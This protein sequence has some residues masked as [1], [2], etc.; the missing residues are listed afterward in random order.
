MPNKKYD[1]EEVERKE[2]DY[3]Q[4]YKDSLD[5]LINR[6]PFNY[7]INADA[8]Y[9]QY[10]DN[11]V[12]QGRQAMKDTIGQASALTGGYG[13]S[14][15]QMVGQ[16]AYD[17]QMQKLND[18][19]PSLYQLA[20]SNYNQETNDL[21]TKMALAQQ[22]MAMQNPTS[23]LKTPTSEM[24]REVADSY[25][26]EGEDAAF[27]LYS[28]YVDYDTDAILS[29]LYG[30]NSATDWKNHAFQV[31]MPDRILKYK[32]SSKKTVVDQYGNEFG[33]RDIPKELRDKILDAD[34]EVYKKNLFEK[35]SNGVSDFVDSFFV[36]K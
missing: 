8:L 34:E 12:M 15:A 18:N 2:T 4:L 1:E 13:N 3:S 27:K 26:N 28:S 23:T 6:K 35:V 24:L 21:A 19:I 9:N 36:R 30:G 10:K 29:Y 25:V 14:Y 11:A 16:Q 20:L 31:A 5:Q 22:G 33:Y 7:D 17:N 32:D